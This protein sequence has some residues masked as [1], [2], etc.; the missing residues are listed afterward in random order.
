MMYTPIWMM[1]AMSPVISANVVSIGPPWPRLSSLERPL[2]I[3]ENLKKVNASAQDPVLGNGLA[4]VIHRFCLTMK[5]TENRIDKSALNGLN[6]GRALA[7]PFPGMQEKSFSGPNGPR[8]N[9]AY[10]RERRLCRGH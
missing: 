6:E 5:K 3:A 7:S 2:T 1:K 10:A 9:H 4:N 8:G